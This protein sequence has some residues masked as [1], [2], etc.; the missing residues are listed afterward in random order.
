MKNKFSKSVALL[1]CL[2]M[3]AGCDKGTA[4]NASQESGTTVQQAD[5]MSYISEVKAKY[6]GKESADYAEPMYNLEKDHVFTFENLPEEYFNLED[7]DCFSVYY[8][9]ELKSEVDISIERDYEKRTVTISPNLT[10]FNSPDEDGSLNKGTW[11]SRSKFWLV[12]NVDLETGK[13]LDKPVI[14]VFT[15]KEEMNTPTLKQSVSSTGF[16][17]LSWNEVEGADYY[18]VYEY[19][20]AGSGSS[21]IEV[22]TESTSCAYDDFETAK[23]QKKHFKETYAGTEIDVDDDTRYSMNEM[24]NNDD[25]YFVVARTNDGKCSGMSN[26][27][28]VARIGNQIPYI[29]SDDFSRNYE[30]DTTTALPAYAKVEMVDGSNGDFLID[31]HGAVCSE[32]E[33]GSIHI[34]CKFKNLPIYLPMLSFTG[35]E[36]KTFMKDTELIA[37]REDELVTKSGTGSQDISIPYLPDQDI[38]SSEESSKPEETLEPETYE[39]PE[40]TPEPEESEEPLNFETPD[41]TRKPEA[42]TTLQETKAPKKKSANTNYSI[43]LDE[44]LKNSVYATS[45]MTEWIAIN[46]LSGQTEIY[47]GDFPEQ[48]DSEKIL[49]SLLEAYNQN[50][51]IG[52]MDEAD[53]D[54]NTQTLHVTYVQSEEET[55]K[56]QE[57]SIAK[58]KEIVSSIIANDM[59]DYEKEA[60][61]NQYLCENG[62]YNEK[63]FDYINEDGTID[64]N[65]TR[66]FANSFTP[67]GILVENEGVCESYAESFLL[68]AKE[69][70]LDAIIVTGTLDGVNHE[71][72]RV[73]L[74]DSW[75]TLDVTNND[76]DTVPNG[77]FNLSDQ[78]ASNMLKEN[79]NFLEDTSADWLEAPDNNYEYYHKNNWIAS[80]KDSAV[81]ILTELL[82]NKTQ[83]AVRLEGDLD[84]TWAEQIAQAACNQGNISSAKYYY[85]AGVLSVNKE[86]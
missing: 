61:I 55:K 13:M 21:F 32:Y 69:A 62:S 7:Y 76:S 16:Y 78:L 58:A 57:A 44:D 70:G 14:I 4:N 59:N 85:R 74:E 26:I 46:M 86:E 30:G 28:E 72:N 50:P 18:E 35:M 83:A 49:S 23:K 73:R 5:A 45:A 67:Y 77:Y 8:D 15:T 66:D 81:S 68:L 65:A 56:M 19:S 20:D 53:Y 79:N 11:G 80:E 54:Y 25:S 41:I 17:T 40:E 60:A 1:L 71:W 39:T 48:A 10:F 29:I 36:F 52:I 2:A 12:R 6:A 38:P 75:Y 33:D 34:S 51:L 22:T 24:L 82:Q 3:A 64:P 43:D 27:C 47:L 63:I 31:Y 84:E 42:T 37:K 9:S